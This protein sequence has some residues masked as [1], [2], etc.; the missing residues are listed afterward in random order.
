MPPLLGGRRT[1]TS[2]G[3]SRLRHR[4]DTNVPRTPPPRDLR[5]TRVVDGAYRS[6]L[7]RRAQRAVDRRFLVTVPAQRPRA[8][9]VLVSVLSLVVVGLAALAGPPAEASA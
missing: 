7:A 9:A 1:P 2:Y 5:H 6:R 8:V 4:F 3:I